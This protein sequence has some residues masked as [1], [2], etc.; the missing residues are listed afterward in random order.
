MTDITITQS[1]LQINGRLVKFN[2][3]PPMVV[4]RGPTRIKRKLIHKG[5]TLYLEL[6]YSF[7]IDLE[8]GSVQGHI[9]PFLAAEY[10]CKKWPNGHS[11]SKV[12][13]RGYSLH[14]VR[15]HH[16]TKI[17]VVSEATVDNRQVS[18]DKLVGKLKQI[19]GK[20]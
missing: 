13:S 8:R 17:G 3:K 4:V 9:E 2:H 11:K 10:P 16:P 5:K 6:D 18:V 20:M 15:Q 7:N 1:F 14:V 12:V 19:Y